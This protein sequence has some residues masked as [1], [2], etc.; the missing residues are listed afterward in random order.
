MR[1]LGISMFR[2]EAQTESLDALRE[3][4]RAFKKGDAAAVT[5]NNILSR[6]A[7]SYEAM[8]FK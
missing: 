7:Y 2:I 3:I 4:I 8:R 1:R 6:Y 5:N